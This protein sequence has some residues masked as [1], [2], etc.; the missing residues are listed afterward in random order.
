MSSRSTVLI[1]RVRTNNKGNQALSTAWVELLRRAFPAD[2]IRIYERRP[3]H[4]LQYTVD[5]F[6]RA[7]DPWRAFDKITSELAKLAPLPGMGQFARSASSIALDE[8]IAS[9]RPFSGLRQRLEMRRWAAWAGAYKR[10]YQAR[11]AACVAARMVVVNPAGEFFPRDP[12]PALFHLLDVHVAHK[13]GRP[14]AIVNHTLDIEDR[15]LR[16]II[17]MLYRDLSLVEFRDQKSVTAL[18]DMGGSLDNVVVAPDLALATAQP[19]AAP[20]RERTVAVA[21]HVPEEEAAGRLPDWLRLL[22]GLR[23]RG[24]EVTL[25]SNEFPSDAEFFAVALAQTGTH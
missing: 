10:A 17:P 23:E 8:R 24:F 18:K 20:R 1:T 7:R 4:L 2:T 19:V 12:T 15:T 16:R 14:S 6:A 3:A 25:V 13:L 11:L 22:R 21:I 9:K 5:Q